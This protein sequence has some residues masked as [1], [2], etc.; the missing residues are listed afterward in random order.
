[1]MSNLV[2]FLGYT[3]AILLILGIGGLIAD[4][5][6]PHI[7]FIERFIGSSGRSSTSSFGPRKIRP[8]RSTPSPTINALS[9]LWRKPDGCMS[10]S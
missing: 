7:P 6:F 9:K 1:M 10:I 8:T 3:A 5:V 2:P 4:Y